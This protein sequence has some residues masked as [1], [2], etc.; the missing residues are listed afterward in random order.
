MA[1][2]LN[3]GALFPEELVPNL[4]NQVKGKSS[5]ATLAPQ[6]PIAFNGQRE[7]TFSFDKEIDVVAESGAKTKGG[8]TVSPVTIIPVKVEYGARVSDE[9]L[10]ASEEAQIDTLSAFADGFARKVAK[11]FDIMALHGFNPRT[12]TASSVIGANNFDSA[13][14]QVVTMADGTTADESIESA[15]ALV[16]GSENDVSGLAFAPAFR[17]ALASQT[18]GNGRK[19]YPELAWGNTPGTING[20]PVVSNST[21]SFGGSLDR[22]LVGDFANSFRWG[23]AKEIPLEI[24]QYGNPDNDET[25]GDLKGHNQIYIRG[26]MYIGWGVLVPDAFAWV[27]AGS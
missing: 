7:F 18:D 4:I 27:K 5:L 20:L 19:I 6:A 25:L 11:G 17:A 12:G 3:K 26:E 22:A 9:Y 16:E 2:V 23:Y 1:D 13:V 15:I 8:V 14:T 24:I 10:Y 21:V